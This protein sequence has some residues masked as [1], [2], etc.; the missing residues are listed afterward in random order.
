MN[1]RLSFQLRSGRRRLAN[2]QTQQT[3]QRKLHIPDEVADLDAQC[4]GHDLKCLN[5]DVALAAFDLADMRAIQPRAVGEY[6]L[7]PFALQSQ[8]PNGLPDPL[9]NVLH[10]QQFRATL[11]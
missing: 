3:P 4:I 1:R 8:S 10:L 5:G 2:K 11:V 6:I 7:R 9:L